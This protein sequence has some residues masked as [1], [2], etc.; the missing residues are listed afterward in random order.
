M[1]PEQIKQQAFD[2]W[3]LMRWGQGAAITPATCKAE[4]RAFDFVWS[5]ATAAERERNMI[6]IGCLN[7]LLVCYRTGRRP[8]ESLLNQLAA[9]REGSKP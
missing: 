2:Q 6:E 1:T 4:M 9:I 7:R 8:S 5:A 3:L